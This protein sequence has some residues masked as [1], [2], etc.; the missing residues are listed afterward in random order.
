MCT[1]NGTEWNKRSADPVLTYALRIYLICFYSPDVHAL[2]LISS[3]FYSVTYGIDAGAQ[4]L[5]L[6][7]I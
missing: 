5:Y 2:H 3:K 4:F 1:G 6:I 7:D